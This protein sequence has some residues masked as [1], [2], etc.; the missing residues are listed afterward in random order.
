MNSAP[1]AYSPGRASVKPSSSA[2][3]AK[4]RVRNLHEHARA[5]AGARIGADGAAMFQIADDAQRVGD[6]L[7]RLACP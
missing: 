2:L 4:K 6:D 7:M 3:R 1:T 5:V